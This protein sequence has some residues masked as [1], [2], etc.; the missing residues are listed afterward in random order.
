MCCCACLGLELGLGGDDAKI[1]IKIKI[2]SVLPNVRS[3]S[4]SSSYLE[5]TPK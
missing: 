5:K 1:K 3:V 2:K 4:T